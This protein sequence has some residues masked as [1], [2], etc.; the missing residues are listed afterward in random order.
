MMPFEYV[1]VLL[2]IVISIAFAHM[3]TG[4]ARMIESGSSTY[5]FLDTKCGREFPV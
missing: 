1:S 2:S 5:L 4:I 3:L